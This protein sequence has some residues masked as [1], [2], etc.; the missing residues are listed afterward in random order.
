[1]EQN[2]GG[3]LEP[4]L[5]SNAD[6]DELYE[7]FKNITNE[8][9]FQ[10]VGIRKRKN[11][12]GMPIETTELCNDRRKA[13]LAML[14]DPS[15]ENKE[16]YRKLNREVKNAVRRIKN[17]SL[18]GKVLQLEEHFQRNESHHLFKSVRNLK[19]NLKVPVC[20]ERF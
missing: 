3:S 14:T 18:E 2:L 10:T 12:E 8:V 1:M 7:R 16:S 6:V 4:L 9:T 13:R 11:V 17:H 15:T 19:E 20:C 5:N